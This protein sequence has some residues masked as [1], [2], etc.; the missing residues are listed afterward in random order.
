MFLIDITQQIISGIETGSI[1]ALFAI[2][3]V[4]IFKTSKIINFAQGHMAMISTYIAFTFMTIIGF[5]YW[6]A[7]VITLIF[8]AV[9]GLITERYLLR[10]IK[11]QSEGAMLIITLGL[12]M[13]LEGVAMLIWGNDIK[14]FPSPISSSPII[15]GYFIITKQGLFI[16]T[17]TLIIIFSIYIFLNK[18]IHGISLKAVSENDKTASLMGVNV[19]I[20]IGLTWAV[21]TSLGAISGMLTAP[22]TYL[23]PSMM[24]EVQIKSFTAAVLGGFDS[25]IGAL[26]GGILVGIFENFIG[27]YISTSYKTVF[28]LLLIII[29]LIFKPSGLFGK[30]EIRKI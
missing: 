14:P 26:V 5:S 21:A 2:G 13:I 9:F 7:F 19:G 24:L 8:A 4:L 18:S 10:P 28:S 23:F 11:D 15:L 25:L 3:L 20:V 12:L 16:F 1:Y 17:I 27:F 30:K 29:I 22:S 6:I